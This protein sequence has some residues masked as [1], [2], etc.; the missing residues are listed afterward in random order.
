MTI[1]YQKQL[2]LW[3]EGRKRAVEY[4]R[5]NK[6]DIREKYGT[7]YIAVM[8]DCGV[9]DRDADK[10]RLAKRIRQNT[11]TKKFILIYTIEDIEIER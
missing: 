9:I 1:E 2:E 3:E 6:H 10:F 4:V 5:Q 7:D 8:E 11:R